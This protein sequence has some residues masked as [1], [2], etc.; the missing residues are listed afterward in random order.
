MKQLCKSDCVIKGKSQCLNTQVRFETRLLGR[1]GCLCY[2]LEVV[3]VE[4]RVGV[5]VGAM[6]VICIAL[7]CVVFRVN[8]CIS[9]ITC[10]R[11]T[12]LHDS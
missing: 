6:A 2:V 3:V 9:D 11:R 10:T 8:G 1:N 5:M 4:G 7:Y 12:Q